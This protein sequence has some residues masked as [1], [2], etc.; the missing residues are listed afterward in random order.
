MII[1]SII[2]LLSSIGEETNQ[3]YA[4]SVAV[5]TL[6]LAVTAVALM[7]A[8]PDQWDKFGIVS[9]CSSSL[10]LFDE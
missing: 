10:V 3:A 5:I 6:L 8:M 4:I 9:L 2:L 7:N 1:A